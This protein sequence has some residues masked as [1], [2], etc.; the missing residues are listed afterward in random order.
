VLFKVPARGISRS[1]LHYFA[2]QLQEYLVGGASFCCLVTDDEELQALNKQFLEKDYPTDVL[3]FPSHG[4]YGS[5]G[6][7][8]ISWD[9]AKDQ[10]AEYGHTIDQEIRIL[11]LHGVLH[12]MGM[13]HEKDGGEM[14]RVE[15]DWRKR[16][17]LPTGIIERVQS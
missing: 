4:P 17:K 7:I 9:R 3:S 2:R 12:L 13:D 15:M 1:K 14:A 6:D 16:L 10:A 8:A 5:V 11:I